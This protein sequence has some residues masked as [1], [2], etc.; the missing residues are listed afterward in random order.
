M[1]YSKISGTFLNFQ[2]G[3]RIDTGTSYSSQYFDSDKKELVIKTYEHSKFIE[4]HLML[5]EPKWLE[6]T[7]RSDD[8]RIP[9]IIGEFFNTDY[10]DCILSSSLTD[11][12][13][14]ISG[15]VTR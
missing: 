5:K 13:V 12:N 4:T 6:F 1:K 10:E 3:Q 11:K 2:N 8:P 15:V 9:V 14:D 7:S